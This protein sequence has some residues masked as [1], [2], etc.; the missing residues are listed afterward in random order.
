LAAAGIPPADAFRIRHV[1][2]MAPNVDQG[3]AAEEVRVFAS[4][5]DMLTRWPSDL[6]P[7]ALRGRLTVYASPE[8]RALYVSRIL[9]RSSERL[10][11]IDPGKTDPELMDIYSK[12]GFLD[13][14]I[15]EGKRTDWFGHSYFH[16]NPEVSSDLVQ[17]IRYDK[18]PGEPGRA[19]EKI[20]PAVWRL[21]ET[22][23]DL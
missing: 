22:A 3:V 20:G 18:K 1:V 2:L 19:L 17:L 21:P 8:D 10:G 7:E 9:F 6:I 13:F 15:Y 5:P 12:W 14:V 23:A 4:D 11:Q 16:T